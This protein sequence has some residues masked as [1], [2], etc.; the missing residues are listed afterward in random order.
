MN[1]PAPNGGVNLE[2]MQL[3]PLLTHDDDFSF[4]I[5]GADLA[6]SGKVDDPTPP[7]GIYL[8]NLNHIQGGGNP[9]DS[10]AFFDR[11]YGN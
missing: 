8:A 5:L 7:Y 9:F 4:A 6:P 10:S 11:W 1:Y 3:N 2:R